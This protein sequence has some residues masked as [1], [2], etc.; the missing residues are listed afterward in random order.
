MGWLIA[1]IIPT[2]RSCSSCAGCVCGG[3]IDCACTL[4]CSD[5]TLTEFGAVSSELA[6]VLVLSGDAPTTCTSTCVKFQSSPVLPS[7]GP[8]TTQP[9]TLVCL[10]LKHA[11]CIPSKD[12][13]EHE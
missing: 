5:A 11:T 2:L 8:A 6:F 1:A 4:V 10:A 9:H 7:Q 13:E 3:G 12:C